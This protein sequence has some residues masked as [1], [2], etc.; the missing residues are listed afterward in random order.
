MLDKK[1]TISEI[2]DII[3]SYR[4]KIDD[5]ELIISERKKMNEPYDDCKRS[6][7]QFEHEIKKA[8]TKI[9]EIQSPTPQDL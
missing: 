5:Q 2:E 4:E 7:E 1:L 6:I 8:L 9:K 3:K